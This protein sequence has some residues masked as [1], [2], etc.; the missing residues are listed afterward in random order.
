VLGRDRVVERLE[1]L[2]EMIEYEEG[3]LSD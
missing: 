1:S 2:L 3:N